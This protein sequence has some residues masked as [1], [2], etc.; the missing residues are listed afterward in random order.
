MSYSETIYSL[1]STIKVPLSNDGQKVSGIL[2]EEKLS[3]GH[4][5]GFLIDFIFNWPSI[6]ITTASSR[7]VRV[8]LPVKTL[9]AIYQESDRW[10]LGYFRMARKRCSMEARSRTQSV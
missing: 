7:V 2:I 6:K 4:M 10:L 8:A 1:N 5:L 3:L 9:V